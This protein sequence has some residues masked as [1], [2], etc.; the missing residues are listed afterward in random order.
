M[1]HLPD[2]FLRYLSL[3]PVGLEITEGGCHFTISDN[4]DGCA[5]IVSF[6]TMPVTDEKQDHY[7]D[8]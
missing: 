7:A 6:L 1:F 5:F 3:Y 2:D 8:N 4:S